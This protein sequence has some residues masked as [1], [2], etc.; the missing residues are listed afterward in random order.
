MWVAE[1]VV[2]TEIG[3]EEGQHLTQVRAEDP[4]P[5]GIGIP[6][7]NL[8]IRVR[9]IPRA[10]PSHKAVARTNGPNIRMDGTNPTAIAVAITGTSQGGKDPNTAKRLQSVSIDST[11][12]SSSLEEL[13]HN[14]ASANVFTRNTS[15][16]KKSALRA[17]Q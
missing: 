11:T 4:N 17:M 2:I 1:G 8:A 16:K 6:S 5:N 14:G 9:A 10:S 7:P 3:L 12:L 13:K 15:S